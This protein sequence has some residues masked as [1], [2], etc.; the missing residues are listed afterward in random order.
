LAFEYI[1]VVCDLTAFIVLPSAIFML[2][3]L[4]IVIVE[5]IVRGG[6]PSARGRERHCKIATGRAIGAQ[7]HD[8]SRRDMQPWPWDDGIV[9]CALE[10]NIAVGGALRAEVPKRRERVLER[11]SGM[12]ACQKHAI[13]KRLLKDLVVQ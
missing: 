3:M 6:F 2:A 5:A 1:S 13:G 11:R 10:I 7:S 4:S 8:G 12:G 9:D